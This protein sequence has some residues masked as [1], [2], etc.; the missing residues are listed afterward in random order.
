[1][2][3]VA[4]SRHKWKY[5]AEVVTELHPD[6]PTIPLCIAEMNQVVLNLIVNAAHA[7]GDATKQRDGAKGVITLR[8]KQEEN[9]V[10]VEVLDNGTGITASPQSHIL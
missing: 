10:L 7:I 3:T 1:M 9:C 4:V 8:T 5:V 6:L 2:T